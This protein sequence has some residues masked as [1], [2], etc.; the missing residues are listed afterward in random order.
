MEESDESIRLTLEFIEELN[1]AAGIHAMAVMGIAQMEAMTANFD[2]PSADSTLYVGHG[3]PDT[4]EGFAYQRW[5][6]R[7]LP[8]RLAPE[9]PVIRALGQQWLVTVAALWNDHYRTRIAAALDVPLN[10]VADVAMADINRMRNDVVHHRGIATRANTGRCD[11]F[12]WFRS[13]API[14]VMPVHVAEL[15]SYVGR[16]EPSSEAGGGGW[17]LWG[18]D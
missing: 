6:I 3:D 17:K 10:D 18:T 2:A 1:D 11:L 7:S 16:V 8:E 15:M 13:G 5:L 9:G 4:D 12:R 14:H